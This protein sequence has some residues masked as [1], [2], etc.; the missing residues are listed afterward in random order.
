MQDRYNT[1]QFRY[2]TIQYN[3]TGKLLYEIAK[4][5]EYPQ[6]PRGQLL[7]AQVMQSPLYV[8][9]NI[10]WYASLCRT[11]TTKLIYLWFYFVVYWLPIFTSSKAQA[12]MTALYFSISYC[13]PNNM[14]SFTV[15]CWIHGSWNASYSKNTEY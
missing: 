10:S 13:F 14:F 8:P 12:R 4:V 5:A 15:A 3:A 2:N 1:I 7:R 11:N 6:L 9:L